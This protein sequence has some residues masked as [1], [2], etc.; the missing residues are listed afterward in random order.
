[1]LAGMSHPEPV[2]VPGPRPIALDDRARDNLRFIRE[3]M[4]RAGSFTAV[5]GWGGVAMGLTAVGA[6]AIAAQQPA[7]KAWLVT[8]LAEAFLACSI[9]AW[10]AGMKSR[11]AQVPLFAGPGRKFALAFAPPL[12]AAALLTA[13]LFRAGLRGDLPGAWLLL[14]GSAVVAAGTFSI[15]VV[16]LMG[17]CFMVLGA[18]ALFSPGAWGDAFMAAG[19]GGLHILF[20]AIIARR[21]GG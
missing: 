14:Y 2:P 1:M 3:T 20:G 8:W 10:S 6:A 9:A 19:F 21:H 5:P 4:E 11:A 16:P 18:V 13:V 15:R 7:A 17:L 12:A